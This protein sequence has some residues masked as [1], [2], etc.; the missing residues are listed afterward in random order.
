M[1]LVVVFALFVFM[2]PLPCFCVATVFSVNKDLYKA[3]SLFSRATEQLFNAV[4]N[5]AARNDR[6]RRPVGLPSFLCRP[7]QSIRLR[8]FGGAD[9]TRKRGRRRGSRN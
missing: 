2:L 4:T 6:P 3:Y 5:D 1:D 9:V 8:F 7:G